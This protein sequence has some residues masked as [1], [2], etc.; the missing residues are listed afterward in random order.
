M[1]KL[2]MT[3]DDQERYFREVVKFIKDVEAGKIT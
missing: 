2:L 3:Y 1:R